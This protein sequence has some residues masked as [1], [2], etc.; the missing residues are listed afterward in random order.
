MLE[1]MSDTSTLASRTAPGRAAARH[2]AGRGAADPGRGL[3]SHGTGFW[4]VTG[5]FALITVIASLPT[6][7]YPLYRQQDHF[8]TLMITV[9]FGV[10]SAGVL[11]TLLTAGHLSDHLGRR[12][13]ILT[14]VG[15]QL[16]ATAVYISSSSL[17]AL[18][19]GRIVSGMSVGLLTSAAT[20]HLGELHAAARPGAHPRRAEMAAVAANLGGIA[21]GPLV[22]GMLA[23]W[24][25]QPLRYSFVAA[26]ALM[27]VTA[28][29]TLLVPETRTREQRTG[30]FRLRPLALPA[31][32]RGRFAAA[33]FAAL[34]AFAV[35][36]LVNATGPTFLA[37]D[38][39]RPSHL[40]AGFLA[41]VGVAAGA[42]VQIALVQAQARTASALGVAGVPIGLALL[43][44]GANQS[45]LGL[46][47]AGVIVSGAGAGA[48]FKGCIATMAQ[49]TAPA[50][51]AG[52]TATFFTGAY[53]GLSVPAIGLGVAAQHIGLV[54]ALDVFAVVVVV[55]LAAAGAGLLR[56][57]QV[58]PP[59]PVQA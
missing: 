13:V 56:R 1:S 17:P 14:A 7:L 42:L 59:A 30:T 58:A 45:S 53:L 16:A 2:A 20:A 44:L 48:L 10:Y 35:Y 31:A 29:L 41:C 57:P 40:L 50:E 33:V 8:S 26:A 36:G 55:A 15:V 27:V 18:L 23:Q 28:A 39:G 54:H 22:G 21:L 49:L 3:R 34:A 11:C 37:V 19:T 38:L 47:L 12:T 24:M 9:A 6:P 32:Q 5:V 51:R 25:P 52:V 43:V 4:L 46:F